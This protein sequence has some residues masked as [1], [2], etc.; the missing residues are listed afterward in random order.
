MV[1]RGGSAVTNQKP[2]WG[3]HSG[4]ATDSK[5]GKGAPGTY[6]MCSSWWC[7]VNLS[8]RGRLS[9]HRQFC[10]I[11]RCLKS[12]KWCL[13]CFHNRTYNGVFQV[14][15]E[16]WKQKLT[17]TGMAVRHK[18]H[19]NFFDHPSYGHK[20]K[21]W[22]T[23]ALEERMESLKIDQ[24]IYRVASMFLLQLPDNPSFNSWDIS[25]QKTQIWASWWH[26]RRNQWAGFILW[27]QQMPVQNFETV[28][29]AHPLLSVTAESERPGIVLSRIALSQN[30]VDW[31][32][33]FMVLLHIVSAFTDVA[34]I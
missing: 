20:L 31:F 8:P 13:K 33:N 30:F 10:N 22:P 3:F 17:S 27:K 2:N 15:Q 7:T 12:H 32:H 6:S 9:G 18:S 5:T 24:F 21:V 11:L 26:H 16:H 19:L 1:T 25:L 29:E 23:G 28:D 34:T 4:K 14:L